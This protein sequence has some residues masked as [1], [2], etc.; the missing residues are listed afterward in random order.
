MKA[1]LIVSIYK[2]IPALERILQSL[3]E[4]TLQDFELILSEDGL[5][6]RIIYFQEEPI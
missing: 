1:S 3:R 2:N 5:Y 4:Q 6:P